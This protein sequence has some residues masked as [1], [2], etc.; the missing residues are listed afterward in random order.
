MLGSYCVFLKACLIQ[1]Q[2]RIQNERQSLIRIR[3]NSFQFNLTII[4]YVFD[5]LHFFPI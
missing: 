2:I 5:H 3:K 1:I 4:F